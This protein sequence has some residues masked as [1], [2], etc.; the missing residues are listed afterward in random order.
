M[1][2]VK[3]LD[4]YLKEANAITKQTIKNLNLG[5]VPITLFFNTFKTMTEEETIKFLNDPNN[6]YSLGVLGSRYHNSQ[7]IK[8][9]N[10]LSKDM[11][12]GGKSTL[13]AGRSNYHG[14]H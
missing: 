12:C 14:H 7:N 11:T 5:D 3:T 8:A 13:S 10:G 2:K 4:S 1:S 9:Y 6:A